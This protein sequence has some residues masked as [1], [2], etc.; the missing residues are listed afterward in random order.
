M[1]KTK[2]ES[3]GISTTDG[4]PDEHFFAIKEAG[5]LKERAT[6]MRQKYDRQNA[7]SKEF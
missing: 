4:E 3:V 6:K 2:P 1:K 5:V 7:I